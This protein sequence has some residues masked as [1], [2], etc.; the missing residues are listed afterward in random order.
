MGRPRGTIEA[1]E[2]WV[3]VRQEP[4]IMPA[5]QRE[6]ARLQEAAGSPRPRVQGCHPSRVLPQATL[7]VETVVSFAESRF[8]PELG[9]C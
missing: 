4:M 7:L 1:Q 9:Q 5:L 3:G 8:G 6:A 2:A